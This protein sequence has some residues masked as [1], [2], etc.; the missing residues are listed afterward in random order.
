MIV[1]NCPIVNKPVL[2]NM[3]RTCEKRNK[4]ENLEEQEKMPI[5]ENN[6]VKIIEEAICEREGAEW[7]K[8]TCGEC[9]YCTYV[10]TIRESC[11]DVALYEC[12]CE[13]S[14]RFHSKMNEFHV[15]RRACEHFV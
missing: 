1:K 12:A 11:C 8:H 5:V 10:K 13:E 3:C 7:K 9:K 14:K 6:L 2:P 15:I 4:C